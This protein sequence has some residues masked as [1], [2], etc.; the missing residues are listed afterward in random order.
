MCAKLTRGRR[1]LMQ[2]FDHDHVCYMEAL[3]KLLDL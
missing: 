1:A 2:L 3:Q